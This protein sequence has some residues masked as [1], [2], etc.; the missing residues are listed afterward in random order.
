MEVCRINAICQKHYVWLR[1]T[2]DANIPRFAISAK[3]GEKSVRDYVHLGFVGLWRPHVPADGRVEDPRRAGEI[4]LGETPVYW[5]GH[6]AFGGFMR[7][8]IIHQ[9]DSIWI[10]DASDRGDVGVNSPTIYGS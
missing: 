8:V 1:G 5:T 3:E 4:P 7:E 10:R 2:L 9:Y 6:F